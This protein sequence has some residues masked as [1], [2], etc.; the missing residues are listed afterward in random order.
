MYTLLNRICQGNQ[1]W[2]GSVL[3]S[4]VQKTA[5]V[6]EIDVVTALTAQ[7]SAMHNMMNTHFSKMALG[8]Q[9]S[10]VNVVQ[11]LTTW[12]D[13][14]G[15]SDHIGDTCG[16]N[17]DSVNFLCNEQKGGGQQNYWNTHNPSWRNHSNFSWGRNQSKVQNK[18]HYR[19]R[20][21]IQGYQGQ[22]QI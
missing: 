21:N 20:G 2:N 8:Q 16:A 17:P 13:I 5:G 14:C 6:L 7:I 22:I 18:N 4:V 3:K 9:T 1:E 10:Q 11:Q 12:C 19:S 15:G